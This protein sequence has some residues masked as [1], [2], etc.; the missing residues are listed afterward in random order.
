MLALGVTAPDFE[1][2]DTVSSKM[3][4]LADYKRYP[5]LLVC[6]ICNHCPYVIHINDGLIRL[7]HDYQDKGLGIIAIS[8]NDAKAYPEDG[9]EK[10][11]QQALKLGYPFVYLY[12]EDQSIARAYDAACTPDFYLFDQQRHLRYRGRF[13]ESRPGNSIPV[14]GKDLRAAI[15]A[16]L[17]NEN[18]DENQFPSLG[19]NIKWKQ[20]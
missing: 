1:L 7:A 12:D 16:L 2:R 17:N 11:R 4:K 10:M 20:S 9:P 18:P 5:L 15:D 19:C 3:I 8:S 14:T 13:D 6:F